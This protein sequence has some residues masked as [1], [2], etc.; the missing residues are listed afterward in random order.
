MPAKAYPFLDDDAQP[1]S[2]A[3]LN[4]LAQQLYGE[5]WALKIAQ[6]VEVSPRT[7]QRIKAAAEADR[8]DSRAYGVLNGLRRVLAEMALT[9]D[10]KK[11]D[12][13]YGLEDEP[14]RINFWIRQFVRKLRGEFDE[15]TLV[16]GPVP[17]GDM[18]TVLSVAQ[19]HE[20]CLT[21]FVGYGVERLTDPNLSSN[22]DID[23][24]QL[25]ELVDEAL[26]TL[27]LFVG[28]DPT[29][30]LIQLHNQEAV[31]GSDI[32]HR[33]VVGG[34]YPWALFGF[35]SKADA[36]AA[37]ATIKLAH[38][39]AERVEFFEDVYGADCNEAGGFVWV[40]G[41]PFSLRDM[42]RVEATLEIIFGRGPEDGGRY[43]IEEMR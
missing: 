30:K 35:R 42:T 2:T 18:G 9:A 8:E 15:E 1:N 33:G 16:C 26:S 4:Q 12:F 19:A 10:V 25:I 29:G 40:L 41:S 5:D 11:N 21:R 39:D 20:D 3:I 24:E 23:G 32:G 27:G 17:I 28:R 37:E 22:D 7:C 6:L 31:F 43:W 14:G 36:E 34:A 38:Q 13:L